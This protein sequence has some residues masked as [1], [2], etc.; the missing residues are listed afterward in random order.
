[1]HP[2][3]LAQYYTVSLYPKAIGLV[4]GLVVMVLQC[5]LKGNIDAF[6]CKTYFATMSVW[7]CQCECKGLELQHRL[8]SCVESWVWCNLCFSRVAAILAVQHIV[9]VLGL[10]YDFLLE[11]CIIAQIDRLPQWS[12]YGEGAVLVTQNNWVT[13]HLSCC[14]LYGCVC[15][16]VKNLHFTLSVSMSFYLAYGD[17]YSLWVVL[18]EPVCLSVGLSKSKSSPP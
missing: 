5:S 9:D 14:S 4:C 3:F 1:M 16:C 18:C 13:R 11:A 17:C 8:I 6:L 7:L 12:G 10:V 15:T 2:P